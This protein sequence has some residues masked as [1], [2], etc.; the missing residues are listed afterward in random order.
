MAHEEPE[1]QQR[2]IP[3]P[4]HLPPREGWEEQT[5]YRNPKSKSFTG[6][7]SFMFLLGLVGKWGKAFVSQRTAM[8]TNLNQ[9]QSLSVPS[10]SCRDKHGSCGKGERVRRSSAGREWRSDLPHL[11]TLDLTDTFPHLMD[12]LSLKSVWAEVGILPQNVRF[13]F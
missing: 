3:S 10:N 1:H 4:Q 9:S 6:H 11:H 12:T 13:H 2:P 7:P 5:I 8:S